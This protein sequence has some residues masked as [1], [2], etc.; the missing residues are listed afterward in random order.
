MQQCHIVADGAGLRGLYAF[1][2]AIIEIQQHYEIKNFAGVSAGAVVGALVKIGLLNTNE[3]IS[4]KKI[5]NVAY[6]QCLKSTIL[7]GWSWPKG[8][9]VFVSNL[10]TGKSEVFDHSAVP[11]LC[12]V[13]LRSMNLNIVDQYYDGTITS[14]FPYIGGLNR[15]TTDIPTFGIFLHMDEQPKFYLENSQNPTMEDVFRAHFNYVDAQRIHKEHL[16]KTVRRII[17]IPVM[18][19]KATDLNLTDEQKE[20]LYDNGQEAA[21]E[22]LIEQRKG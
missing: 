13:L 7:E 1:A 16:P 6:D 3:Y 17:Y 14:N 15:T 12:N 22:F 9:Q 19:I 20:K 8:L 5:V 21:R 10:N 18:N 4:N 11:S 2:G